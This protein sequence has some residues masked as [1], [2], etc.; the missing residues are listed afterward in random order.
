MKNT[1]RPILS[2]NA[3]INTCMN[4]LNLNLHRI[5]GM[6]LIRSSAQKRN[7]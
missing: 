5:C 6:I 7:V 1:T 4:G 2:P 3:V